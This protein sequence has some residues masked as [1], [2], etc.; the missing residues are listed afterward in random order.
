M[1]SYYTTR[2]MDSLRIKNRRTWHR[3]S[4]GTGGDAIDFLQHFEGKSFPEAV[5]FLLA[6]NRRSRD[7]PD[8]LPPT[9]RKEPV[10]FV[11]PPANEDQR[12]VTAY[13]KKRGVIDEEAKTA[14]DSESESRA[15]QI[16]RPAV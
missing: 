8:R 16:E 12:R 13:L 6:W 11:L 15:E 3:Y 5:E 4:E 9:Q 7:S 1:G 10:S 2:E 14:D